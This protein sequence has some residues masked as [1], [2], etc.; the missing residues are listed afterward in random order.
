MSAETKTTRLQW[1]NIT[2]LCLFL[3]CAAIAAA[4]TDWISETN[5]DQ[6]FLEL[7]RVIT[8]CRLR[9]EYIEPISPYYSKSYYLFFGVVFYVFSFLF[10][11]MIFLNF[12][13]YEKLNFEISATII[14]IV[15]TIVLFSILFV[16][17]YNPIETREES[18]WLTYN[19][20]ESKAPYIQD[21]VL[22]GCLILFG[23]YLF[24][25]VLLLLRKDRENA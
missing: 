23:T 12:Y 14:I 19:I 9:I 10:S 16:F 17:F 4:A 18:K 21:A 2:L 25:M 7:C 6:H 24:H 11:I 20:H 5:L 22:L 1:V 13:F 8:G 3:V 15:S